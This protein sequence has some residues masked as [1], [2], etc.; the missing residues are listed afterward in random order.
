MCALRAHSYWNPLQL[1]LSVRPQHDLATVTVRHHAFTEDVRRA[2]SAAR[3]AA[4]RLGCDYVGTEHVLLGTLESVQVTRVLR[5]F[6]IDPAKLASEVQARV[7]CA[8]PSHS[9]TDLPYTSRAKHVLQCAMDEAARGRAAAVDT[10]HLLVGLVAEQNGIAAQVLM[11][12]RLGLEQ[13]RAR[14]AD[15]KPSVWRRF[16]VALRPTSA[17]SKSLP[18]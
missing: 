13:L 3:A 18:G 9:D 5:S 17:K 7:R 16:I 4:H 2:L 12:H 1:S 10:S 6:E 11:A 14:V 15:P 8:R